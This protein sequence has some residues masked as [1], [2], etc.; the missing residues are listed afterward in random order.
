MASQL[1]RIALR[2]SSG[3]E[4]GAGGGDGVCFAGTW[5]QSCGQGIGRRRRVVGGNWDEGAASG[6]QGVALVKRW[7][8]SANLSAEGQL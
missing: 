6:C 3:R 2:D 1:N 7:S 5:L 8:R 4:G